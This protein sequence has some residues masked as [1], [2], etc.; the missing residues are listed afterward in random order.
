LKASRRLDTPD[1]GLNE[2]PPL[3]TT[4]L[5]A[6]PQ[7]VAAQGLRDDPPTQPT[8]ACVACPL[9]EVCPG[10]EIAEPGRPFCEGM[11]TPSVHTIPPRRTILHPT[12]WS[13][14]VPVVCRG[15]AMSSVA[16]PD[17]RR[18]VLAF[19]L[20]GDLVSTASLFEPLSGRRVEPLTT[21]TCRMFK[22]SEL[23]AVAFQRPELFERLSK[24]WVEERVQADKLALDLGRRRAEE[25]IARLIQSLMERLQKRGIAQDH[26]I[27]FPLRQ[28]HI[29][30]ATGLTPVHVSKVLSGFRRAGLIRISERILTVL[31]P[32]GFG[33]LATLR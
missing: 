5:A 27:E 3:V 32:V 21:V 1:F 6:R 18:Q 7:S 4:S 24:M 8:S 13:D 10:V 9:H 22:R 15:W 29:A 33:R 20:S 26:T 30:D 11:L 17:G 31:D 25:R 14:F 12:E 28:R 19:H 2:S 23:Q 16:L